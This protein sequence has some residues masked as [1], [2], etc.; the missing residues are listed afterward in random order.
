M[1]AAELQEIRDELAKEYNRDQRW[2]ALDAV[3]RLLAH[4]DALEAEE[5]R[6]AEKLREAE[7]Y[8]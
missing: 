6:M 8:L 7:S 1:T 3:P 4:V 2:L 5:E